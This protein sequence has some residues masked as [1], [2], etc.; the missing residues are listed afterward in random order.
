M[1]KIFYFSLLG[2]FYFAVLVFISGCKTDIN[3]L[4]E[5]GETKLHLAATRSKDPEEILALIKAGADVNLMSNKSI[6]SRG[7]NFGYP[8]SSTA[9]HLATFYNNN[10]EITNTLI[11]AGANVNARDSEGN[12]ALH[13]AVCCN[14]NPE[15][16][17]A[18]IQAGADVN[19]KSGY[20][21]SEPGGY[22]GLSPLHMAS[23]RRNPTIVNTLIQAGADIN[24]RDEYERTALIYATWKNK[25]AAVTTSLIKAGADIDAKD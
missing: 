13:F 8:I 1:N 2:L 25:D 22:Y 5:G 15:I 11:Q 9:L 12:T 24:S 17:E 23:W 3:A 21:S 7:F 18:L 4:N 16:I 19:V 10:L 20:F 14:S 6:F